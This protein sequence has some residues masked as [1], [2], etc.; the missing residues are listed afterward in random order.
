MKLKIIILLFLLFS[1]NGNAQTNQKVPLNEL[2]S[3]FIKTQ[4]IDTLITYKKI[5]PGGT[6]IIVEPPSDEKYTCFD[7]LVNLPIYL[8]WKKGGTFFLTKINYCYEYSIIT[9]ENN[10]FWTMYFSNKTTIDN[11][12]IQPFEHF[13][14]EKSKKKKYAIGISN[15]TFHQFGV[16]IN[17]N[18][19]EKSFDIF[20]LT[21]ESD[22]LIN[23]NYK[24]NNSLKSKEIIDILEKITS[25]AEKNNQFAKI[26]LREIKD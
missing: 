13:A 11:E 26:K 25:E 9:P 8:F 2:V 12:K 24:S 15:S 4:K 10:S 18:K 3:D 5:T 20:D 7:D 6:V 19:T 17:G 1:F 23:I 14:I 21:K 22:G 16:I